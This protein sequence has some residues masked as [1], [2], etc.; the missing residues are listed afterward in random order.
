MMFDADFEKNKDQ[1]TQETEEAEKVLKTEPTL[2]K[3]NKIANAVTQKLDK[4]KD[5]PPAIGLI[6]K[7]LAARIARS[8]EEDKLRKEKDENKESLK[9]IKLKGLN[10]EDRAVT[11]INSQT[12]IV[13]GILDDPKHNA[14]ERMSE[15]M[16]IAKQVEAL[17]LAESFDF[18][19]SKPPVLAGDVTARNAEQENFM[20]TGVNFRTLLKEYRDAINAKKEDIGETLYEADVKRTREAVLAA[21]DT[22]IVALNANL[23][24][25]ADA[26]VNG[27]FPK[28][29]LKQIEAML[30]HRK[31]VEQITTE[32]RAREKK[33]AV[34]ASGPAAGPKPRLDELKDNAKTK[35]FIEMANDRRR[36][37][38]EVDAAAN[39]LRPEFSAM[40]PE[41][42]EKFLQHLNDQIKG[43]D[44]AFKPETKDLKLHAAPAAG[45]D[46]PE[47]MKKLGDA[48]A[49]A[50]NTTKSDK[51]IEDA[52]KA[53]EPEFTKLTEV[54]REKFL[55]QLN[56]RISRWNKRFE[57][58]NKTL[59]Y[60]NVSPAV[61][62][63][64]PEKKDNMN[65]VLAF[66]RD[67]LNILRG[68]NNPAAMKESVNTLER[69]LVELDAKSKDFRKRL[70]EAR[71]NPGSANVEE[72]ERE[73]TRLEE[74]RKEVAA[75]MDILQL[76]ET[77]NIISKE[78]GINFRPDGTKVI[79]T[80][81]QASIPYLTYLHSLV[82][83][84][85][86]SGTTL[87]VPQAALPY[88]N[89]AV[90]A[91]PA[92]YQNT[93]VPYFNNSGTIYGNVAATGPFG[94][95]GFTGKGGT[96][97]ASTRRSV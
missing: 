16:S 87:S 23:K 31:Q 61:A 76:V 10:W 33:P 42:Q 62:A 55:T 39:V 97:A 92:A 24:K 73:L 32:A 58:K 48:F 8:L 93:G 26:P 64:A 2:E 41:D 1:L 78:F 34:P 88:V 91:M 12:T 54:Q 49:N 14:A 3:A 44:R 96:G 75:R 80:C 60:H 65:R 35:K 84:T 17:L 21:K 90:S 83:Q 19:P 36:N 89:Y 7:L 25:V 68:V 5:Y 20:S 85:Q 51:E 47:A 4:H 79:G 37:V 27:T 22:R 52:R 86:F 66:I 82:P 43:Y 71:K 45:P 70:D 77:M 40:T 56:V 28:D 74:E 30:E 13:K 50:V 9:Q 6:Q 94:G 95:P 81:P 11:E 67:L 29:G 18:T 59:E 46:I 72:L 57:P 69:R 63:V 53:M 15:A 38:D